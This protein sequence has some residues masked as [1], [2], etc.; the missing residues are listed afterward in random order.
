M[1]LG[2]LASR[3]LTTKDDIIKIWISDLMSEIKLE[4]SDLKSELKLIKW[5]LVIVIVG[6]GFLVEKAFF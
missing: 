3:L 2:K 5:M 4:I 1:A 6:I